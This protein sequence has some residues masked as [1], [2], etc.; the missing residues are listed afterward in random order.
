MAR[1]YGPL[2]FGGVISGV[3]SGI[4]TANNKMKKYDDNLKEKKAGFIQR[5]NAG[6][7][8]VHD[9][10]PVQ[11]SLQTTKDYISA[12]SKTEFIKVGNSVYTN[13]PLVSSQSE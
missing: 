12:I 6:L 13:M 4:K 7:K 3:P 8:K 2:A 10:E 5:I 9:M 1:A 11:S